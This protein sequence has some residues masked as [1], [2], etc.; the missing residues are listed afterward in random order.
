V[1]D[2]HT[3]SVPEV[4]DWLATTI[5]QAFPDD[6]WVEGE[7]CNLSRSARGHVYFTLIEPGDDRRSASSSLSVTLFDWYRQKVNLAL[8]RAGGAVRMEDGVRVRIRGHLELYAAKGQ[9]QFRMFAI[10]PAFT[11]GDLAIQRER[12]LAS[13]AA[14]GLLDANARL[15]LPD[16]P[17]RVGLVTSLG[18]AA[19]ADFLH[20]LEVSGIGFE[21]VAVDARVQGVEADLTIAAA[22]TELQLRGADVIALVR[23][24]GARTDLAAFDSELIARAIASSPIPVWTG[25]GHEIDRTVA[26]E[27]AHTSFKTPTACAGALVERVR[28]AADQAER[29][30]TR[31]AA[32]AV[33]NLDGARDD[34]RAI[35]RL[36]AV[37]ARA[38][39]DDGAHRLTRD[40]HRLEHAASRCAAEANNRLE[41]AARSLGPAA[42]RH[43][44]RG[45]AALTDRRRRL[46]AAPPRA[47]EQARRELD[48][49]EARARANDPARILARGWSITRDANG[50]VV[51]HVA[52]VSVGSELTTTLTGGTVR[53]TVIEAVDD[54]TFE[55]GSDQGD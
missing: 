4:N 16:L 9:V 41:L 29:A 42:R 54:E 34:M 12:I 31:I 43:L 39:C 48:G 8:R 30:W 6:L 5:A 10:D 47:L 3:W 37:Q 35:A 26:D 23:G 25:I 49:I 50:A 19:H 52:Q 27:V 24:G 46:L 1:S 40:G 22:L 51:R 17:L 33:E 13:L 45:E 53:S 15:A 18:S 55:R 36:L 20:E 38:R 7:I 2:A 44:D 21:L 14:D 11:L 28:F 32:L